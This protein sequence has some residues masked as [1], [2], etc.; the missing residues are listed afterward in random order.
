MIY[1]ETRQSPLKEG[2]APDIIPL[3]HHSNDSGVDIRTHQLL[4]LQ[5]IHLLQ[6]KD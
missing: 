6:Y 2:S 1:T 5:Y 4:D 3:Y